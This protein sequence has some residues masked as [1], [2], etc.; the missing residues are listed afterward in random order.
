VV[1]G[2]LVALLTI[3]YMESRASKYLYWL[4]AVTAL[5]YA[6]MEASFIY[7]AITMLFLGLHLVRELFAV[8][9][10]RPEY[11]RPFQIAFAVTLA[12]LLVMAGLLLWS[13]QGA[14]SGLETA[15]PA[16]PGAA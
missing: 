14:A 10:P 9:W 1:W 15:V 12:A 8:R 7:I 11:R 4:A 16:D 3:R 5:F 13:R 2:L 6:T